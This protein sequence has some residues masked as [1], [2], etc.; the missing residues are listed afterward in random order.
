MR[1]GGGMGWGAGKGGGADSGGQAGTG[2]T[3]G[4]L[5]GPGALLSL[6]SPTP[7]HS[8]LGGQAA[9]IPPFPL[10]SQPP[11]PD[12]KWMPGTA[13]GMQRCIVRTV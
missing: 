1:V 6:L 12:R 4:M 11:S 5:G 13:G 10:P 7:L 9:S 3:R 8:L 2:A